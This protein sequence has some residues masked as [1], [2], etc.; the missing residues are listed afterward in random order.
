MA[1]QPKARQAKSQARITKFYELSTRYVAGQRG[2]PQL[3]LAC[4]GCMAD[5]EGAM[6]CGAGASCGLPVHTTGQ[7]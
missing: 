5:V 2:G 6:C 7:Q 1:K 3:L 4:A